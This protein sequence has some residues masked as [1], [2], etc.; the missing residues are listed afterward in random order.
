VSDEELARVNLITHSFH[1]DWN[2]TIAPA[3]KK[4]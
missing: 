2:Y 1:G 3:H 4:I